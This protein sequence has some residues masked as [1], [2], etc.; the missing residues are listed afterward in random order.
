MLQDEL[1]VAEQSVT[2]QPKWS[3]DPQNSIL[4][5]TGADREAQSDQLEGHMIFSNVFFK[6][7]L[8]QTFTKPYSI[9]KGQRKGGYG[10]TSLR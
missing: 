7:L 2:W 6:V 3:R 4:A 8:W 5:I 1:L 9:L 10:P